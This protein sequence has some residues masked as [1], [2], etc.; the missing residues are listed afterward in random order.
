MDRCFSLAQLGAGH[1]A[2]NPMVGTLLVYND[3][4]IGEGYHRRYGQVH[5]EVN[6]I[7]SVA[8][9]HKSFIPHAT[10]YVSLEPCS[11]YGQTPPCANLIVKEKICTVVIG[12][13]DIYNEV[14]G[15]GIEILESNGV[16]V[17]KGILEKEAIALNKRFFTFHSKQ[18]PYIIL[19]WAQSANGKIANGDYSAVSIS[20]E[21]TNRLV[22]KWRSEEASILV[23]TNTALHDDPSLTNR[24]WHGNDPVR[25]VVDR[26]LK[27]PPSLKLFDGTV[28]TIV[29]NSLKQEERSNLKYYKIARDKEFIPELLIELYRQKIQSVLIEGGAGI[30]QYFIDANL[31]DEARVITNNSLQINNGINGPA[32]NSGTLIKSENILSDHIQYYRLL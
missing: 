2:P 21:Y 8:N 19:K 29:F 4:I 15:K 14:N 11:H 22:H 3:R 16:K 18:R 23:G 7:D 13:T 31:W 26:E 1:V 6:C 30:L 20:N 24:C 25:L 17:I 5:A 9:E 12:C 10:M 32:L 27:L 28:K